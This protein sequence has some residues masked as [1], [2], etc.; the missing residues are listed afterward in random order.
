M[1]WMSWR[2]IVEK[3]LTYNDVLAMNLYELLDCIE[4]MEVYQDCNDLTLRPP[5]KEA[6]HSPVQVG[7]VPL[8]WSSEPN[9]PE[10]LAMLERLGADKETMKK[11]REL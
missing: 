8:P 4:A 6:E 2:P 7:G 5:G 10:A 1:S 9:S 3:V 11:A